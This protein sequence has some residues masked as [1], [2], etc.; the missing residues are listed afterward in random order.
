MSRPPGTRIWD[1]AGVERLEDGFTVALDGRPVRTPSRAALLLPSEALAQAIAAE[2]DAQ[3]QKI[4]PET[5]PLTRAANS[6]IDKVGPS[7]AQIAQMIADYGATDLLCYRAEAPDELIARQAALWDPWVRWS[8]EALDAPLRLAAGIVPVDQP[9]A[10]LE[11]FRALVLAHDA[12]ELTA[13]HDL[14]ALS[15]SLVLGLAVSHRALP[16]PSAWQASRV[17]EHWQAEL[18]GQ[19]DEAQAAAAEKEAAFLS[20]DRLLTLLGG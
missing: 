13:L 12:F 5:M 6:A 3:G 18:W 19:D 11:R 16:A 8:E 14:V 10:T 4:R 17:D 7:H 2:W 9:P 20:A 1:K 15:G